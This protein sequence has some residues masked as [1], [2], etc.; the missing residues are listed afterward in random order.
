M[1]C[2]SYLI[3]MLQHV[4][5][6]PILSEYRTDCV[7]LLEGLQSC[8]VVGESGEVLGSEAASERLLRCSS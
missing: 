7:A 4:T 1:R 8:H 3:M 2:L 5:V 6:Y